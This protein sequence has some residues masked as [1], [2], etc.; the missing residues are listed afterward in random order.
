MPPGAVLL[1]DTD[2]ALARL[3]GGVLVEARA[4]SRYLAD[5]HPVAVA[6]E[7]GGGVA[8]TGDPDDLVRLASPYRNVVVYALTPA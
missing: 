5:A 2:R 1:R 3:V 8:V 4:G 6:V 7:S